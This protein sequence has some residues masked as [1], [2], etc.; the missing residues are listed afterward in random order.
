LS[1]GN[2]G[3]EAEAAIPA[4]I[5]VL[6][7]EELRPRAATALSQIGAAAIPALVA[8]A[9]D[10]DEALRFYAASTLSEI[11]TVAEVAVPILVAALESEDL[12]YRAAAALGDYGPEA[13]AAV[14]AL[15]AGL[16]D[17]DSIFLYRVTNSLI[18]IGAVAVP[19]LAV[20]LE[21]E[22][23]DVRYQ[24][25]GILESIEPAASAAVPALLA[26]LNDQNEGVRDAA[27]QALRR[28]TKRYGEDVSA[29]AAKDYDLVPTL[30]TALY[31]QDSSI[32]AIA[33]ELLGN[34]GPEAK[35]SVPALIGALND[36]ETTVRR[37]AASA[38]GKIGPAAAVA[39]PAL[40]VLIEDADTTVRRAAVSALK[41]IGEEI[42]PTAETAVP[43]LAAL[44]DSSDLVI[45][46]EAADALGNIGAEAT[47]ALITAL[48]DPRTRYGA[49]YSLS[50]IGSP[51]EAAAE[52]L[53]AIA[54]SKNES[55]ELRWLT[56]VVP[57]PLATV[58]QC[59]RFYCLR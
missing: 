52:P 56:A 40:V 46:R 21:A 31:Y 45:R 18:E 19:Q 33:A 12:R 54:N 51:A 50:R 2:I 43:A 49:A 10:E 27:I 7:D 20:A 1:L 26:A 9:N 58:A 47:P 3:P 44:L 57:L 22:A 6:E 34:L 16:N 32:R 55:T 30:I 15:I 23:E 25:A 4:L 17:E 24:A 13:A 48:G 29:D 8:A 53:R 14:N 28:L 37:Q 35:Y 5:T 41:E 42:G 36:S 59:F 39:T 11:G 38:L